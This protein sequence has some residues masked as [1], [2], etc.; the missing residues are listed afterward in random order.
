M[1]LRRLVV[2]AAAG[3]IALGIAMVPDTEVDAVREFSPPMVEVQTDALGLSAAEVEQ[4]I[5]VPL[6]QDLLVGIPFLDEIQSVSLPGLS[7][8]VMTFVPGTDV[9]DARQVVQERLTQAV[10]IAGLPQ[11]SRPP[12]MIQPLA[13]NSRV[14]MIKLSSDELSPIE[15]SV[16]ARWVLGPRLLGVEGVANVA[17]WGNRDLQLQVRVDPDRLQREGTTLAEVIS[18]AGNALEVSPLSYLEASKPGTGGFIDTPNQRLNIFHE[19]TITTARELEQVPLESDGAAPASG[20]TPSLGDV[21]DVVEDHQPLIGDAVCGGGEQCLLMVVEKFPGANTPEVA[22]AVDRALDAMA[23]GLTGLQMDS[24]V[25]Q[26]AE[27]VESSVATMTWVLAAGALLLVL[28]LGVM[29]W[30]WRLLVVVTASIVVASTAALLVLKL[31]ETTLDLFV[32]VGLVVGLTAIIHDAVCGGGH[33][34]DRIREHR[35]L[36]PGAS[37][38]RVVVAATTEMRS[39]IGYAALIVAVASLPLV[40]ATGDGAAFVPTAPLAYLLAVA[41]SLA[42]ALTFTPALTYFVNPGHGPKS[43][44]VRRLHRS[45]DR[46]APRA[47]ARTGLAVGMLAV[48]AVAGVAATPFLE[49]DTRPSLKESD[50]LVTLDAPSGTSLTRMTAIAEDAI[51]EL[52]TVAGVESATAH[53]GRAQMSDRSVDVDSGDVWLRLADDADYDATMDAVRSVAENLEGANA[54]VST[55]TDS[56]VRDLLDGDEGDLVV[57]VFGDDPDALDRAADDVRSQLTTVDGVVAAEVDRAPTQATMEV[58][59]DLDRAQ[60]HGIKPGDVRRVAASVLGGITVGNLFQEQKVFDVVVWG[61]PEVRDTPSDVSRMLIDTPTGGHVRLGEVADVR[62]VDTPSVIK[63]A[64]V[65]GYLDV[66]ANV[67]GRS[68]ADVA[69]DVTSAVAQVD[70]PREHHAELLTGYAEERADLERLAALVA[71]AAVGVLLLLQAGLRSWRIAGLALLLLPV[72]LSGGAVAALV[73]GGTISLGSIAGLLGVLGLAARAIV[74]LVRRFHHLERAEGGSF[75]SETVLHGTRD[76]LVPLLATAAGTALL[77]LPVLVLG[78]RPGLEILH[79]MA[80]VMVGGL[81]ST[82]LV[83]LVVLPALYLRIGST[84]KDDEWAEELFAGVPQ[85]RSVPVG[86]QRSA[87]HR[88]RIPGVLSGL[89][90]LLLTSCGGSVAADSYVVEHEPGHVETVA[91]DNKPRVVL[92]SRAVERLAL[93]TSV[94]RQRGEHRVVPQEA[95][96]VDPHGD[97]WLYTNP[98]PQVFVRERVELLRERSGIGVLAEGPA[99][100]TAVVTVGVAELYGVEEQVGH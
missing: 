40:F 48:L 65:S 53:V 84:S 57:R 55:Y 56:R 33:V 93:E 17:I 46:V 7:S 44:V 85:Q 27:Y 30:S 16:L 83:A 43:P 99:V 4:L 47:F 36:R 34:A 15:M 88:V 77:L 67:A 52:E 82:L 69:E 79:P 24:S 10:G 86:V 26:P 39:S 64:A 35:R 14:S 75:G 8:V 32:L 63:H 54:E 6:E 28:L 95:L 74:V 62:N 37:R 38:W 60:A 29:L 5:T 31:T 1:K 59:V 45:F 41:V 100:G 20:R 97:W 68:E 25:Y 9:L 78:P 98:E 51:T 49:T 21:T 50:V 61:S 96:F 19:Q 12:Q 13:S 76:S 18:T 81:V 2:L 72:S 80:V 94:V 73:T 66:V 71:A 23:P 3:T 91:G 87:M 22:S 42:V 89:S 90:L 70:F 11:V 92:T 58:E